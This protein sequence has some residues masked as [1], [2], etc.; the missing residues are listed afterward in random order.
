MQPQSSI[1]ACFHNNPMYMHYGISIA[2]AAYVI[3]L[4]LVMP[5]VLW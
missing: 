2:V 5:L 3:L 1:E 4:L